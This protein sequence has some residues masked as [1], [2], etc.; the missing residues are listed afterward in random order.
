MKK[1]IFIVISI[2]IILFIIVSELKPMDLIENPFEVYPKNNIEYSSEIKTFN[3][4][5]AYIYAFLND[6]TSTDGKDE[7]VITT[8]DIRGLLKNQ[9][10]IH[11][12]RTIPDDELINPKYENIVDIPESEIKSGSHYYGSIY[13]GIVPTECI[14][15][16]INGVSSQIEQISFNLN[17]VD[18]SFKL[19][20]LFV[21]ENSSQ[22]SANIICTDIRG[23]KH[24]ILDIN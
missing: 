4:K 18:V 13:A 10:K 14:N 15:V 12:Y 7:F 17:G 22:D 20:Y 24:K 9:H 8:V 16:E 3:G 21:E 2:F 23:E 19:Y 6:G 5:S 11:T 1:K